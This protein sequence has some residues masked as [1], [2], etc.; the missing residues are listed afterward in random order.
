MDTVLQAPPASSGVPA[1][2]PERETRINLR[3]IAFLTIVSLP[4]VWFL[5]LFLYNTIRGP[6]QDYGDYKKVDL[7]ALGN[8]AFD[9]NRGTIDDLPQKFRE[10]D[11]QRVMLEGEM[12]ADQAGAQV[13]EFE[14]VYSI[15][16]CCLGGPPKVH[17][18]VYA[19][20]PPDMK[21]P[22]YTR[23][24]YVRVLGTLHV[25]VKKSEGAIVSVYRLDVESVE[26]T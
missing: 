21:V 11:G 18:R 8:F 23:R 2:A 24:G 1:P 20:V 3:L 25:D 7:K 12:W 9:Q 6:I 19:D 5:G 4:F 16:E 15:V 26:P 17:E 14:L 22:N 10:L 13:R